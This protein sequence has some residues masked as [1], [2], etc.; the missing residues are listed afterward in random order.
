[1][2]PGSDNAFVPPPQ[3]LVH[4]AVTCEITALHSS[5]QDA[6]GGAWCHLGD[7]RCGFFVVTM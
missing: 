6:A 4:G 5:H 3:L 2:P 1:M 7:R